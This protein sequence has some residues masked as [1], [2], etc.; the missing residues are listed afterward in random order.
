MHQADVVHRDIKPANILR[1]GGGVV[2]LADLGVAKF[3]KADLAHTVIG[4]PYYMPPE[5][6]K[7]KPYNE[8]SDVW[9]LGCLLYEMSAFKVPFDGKSI[10][11]LQHRICHSAPTRPPSAIPEDIRKVLPPLVPL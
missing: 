10:Q 5:L 9:A 3:L 6:W 8:L 2:K 11:D 1:A 4:T 7:Q